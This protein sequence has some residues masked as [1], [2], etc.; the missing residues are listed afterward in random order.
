M[1]TQIQIA[2]WINWKIQ[3]LSSKRLFL[4]AASY[5]VAEYEKCFSAQSFPQLV[6]WKNITYI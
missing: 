1:D 2:N 3:K 4:F 5:L 6:L